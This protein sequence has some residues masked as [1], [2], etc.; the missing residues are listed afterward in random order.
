MKPNEFLREIMTPLTS[1]AVLLA[2]VMFFLLFQV[3]MLATVFGIVIAAVLAAQLIIFVLPALLR[4][5]MV[6]LEARAFGRE[7]DALDIDLFP[8][9]GNVWTLFP[10]VHVAVFVYVVYLT[11]ANLGANAALCIALLYAFLLPASLVTLAMTHSALAS[12]NPVTIFALIKRR[13]FAYLIGPAF[14]VAATWLVVRINVAFNVDMLT[15]F[16]SFYFVFA[17]FALFGGLVRSLKLER[18]IEIP[19]PASIDAERDQELHL[20]NRT[21]VLNHAYGIVSRGNR[22]KGLEH[23]FQALRDDPYEE[24]GWAWFLENMLRWENPD[25]GLAFAQH[26]VHELLRYGDNVKA[27]KV[28]MRCRLINAAFKPLAEDIDLAV[29]AAEQ[30]HNNELA[31]FLR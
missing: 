18:E 4:Y 25:A 26:Y 19:I 13:G 9:V 17:A 30:C 1:P 22:V 23:I 6:I 21:A 3:A 15:E 29:H 10:I 31:S 16:V 11:G 28:M 8:W 24:A 12:L 14:I 20:I 2:M 5:L 7:P 27:V